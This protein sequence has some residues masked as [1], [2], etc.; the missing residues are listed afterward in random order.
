MRRRTGTAYCTR[1]SDLFKLRRVVAR[2][3][4]LFFVALAASVA[5]AA[6][7]A[8]PAP[9]YI[10]VRSA[11]GVTIKL[12]G[13]FKGV[14][15][16]EEGLVIRDVAAGVHALYAFL[17][18]HEDQLAMVTVEPAAI[19][20]LKLRPFQPMP[21]HKLLDATVKTGSVWVEAIAVNA[22]VD[23]KK[24]GWKKIPLEGEP[25]VAA[26]VPA[27]QHKLTFC[28]PEKCIDYR[29]NVKA[30]D[31]LAL[32]VDFGINNIQDVTATKKNSWA[33]LK[34]AC[35][36]ARSSCETSCNVELALSPRARPASCEALSPASPALAS[37][38]SAVEIA[39]PLEPPC[40]PLAGDRKGWLTIRTTPAASL[41]VRDAKLGETPLSRVE[42]PAG[43]VELR[44]RALEGDREKTLRVEVEPDQITVYAIE[45]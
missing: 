34:D 14:V 16:N 40:V 29:A 33:R 9:G 45:L 5:R 7:A 42:L 4:A 12:D 36:G 28:N 21:E 32:V 6:F 2:C 41:F 22:T 44:A 8:E 1:S 3:V 39:A 38:A 31:I 17:N 26:N 24:L 10:H 27:G 15:E 25:F 37:F 11:P 18:G 35:A 23:S 20:V 43:C 30:D 19:A 13:K